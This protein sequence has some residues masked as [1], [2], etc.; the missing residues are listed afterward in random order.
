MSAVTQHD[1]LT[2][3]S[4][5]HPLESVSI[6]HIQARYKVDCKITSLTKTST[7]SFRSRNSN[8]QNETWI[9]Y[10]DRSATIA[11]TD[12]IWQGSLTD[13]ALLK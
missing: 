9:I 5:Q 13:K 4:V 10:L 2:F 12:K 1:L 11:S 8:N 6:H 7:K 3:S